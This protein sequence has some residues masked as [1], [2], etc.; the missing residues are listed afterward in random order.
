MTM[1]L[2]ACFKS[3]DVLP[4]SDKNF[5]AKLSAFIREGGDSVE[6]SSMTDFE[7][8]QFGAVDE[9]TEAAEIESLFGD[10]IIRDDRYLSSTSLFVFLKDG[11][12]VKA[13]M[14]TPDVFHPE[15]FGKLFG[16][17]VLLRGESQ[18]LVRF[19]EPN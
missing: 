4:S 6:L 11:K 3:G 13:L 5:D 7:W 16:R 1:S 2:A 12:V 18:S 14:V 19:A 15:D 8:D 17:D 10:R 9:G